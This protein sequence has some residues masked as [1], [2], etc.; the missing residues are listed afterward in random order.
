MFVIAFARFI[1]IAQSTNAVFYIG[2]S[3]FIT[4]AA[5]PDGRLY[6]SNNELCKCGRCQGDP[7]LVN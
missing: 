2:K 4:V 3:V 7:V 1:V 5:G 6:P